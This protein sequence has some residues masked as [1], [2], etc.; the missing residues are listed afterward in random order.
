[1][2][3]GRTGITLPC[4]WTWFDG[5]GE[6]QPDPKSA[7]G[8]FLSI[9]ITA[10]EIRVT[11]ADRSLSRWHVSGK[12][13]T[14]TVEPRAKDDR[15]QSSVKTQTLYLRSFLVPV[16]LHA[17]APG[18]LKADTADLTGQLMD[19]VQA[20]STP[21]DIR[22][23]GKFLTTIEGRA[24]E[25]NFKSQRANG[26]T[27]VALD[28]AELKQIGDLTEE[29]LTDAEVAVLSKYPSRAP[30]LLEIQRYASAQARK[31]GRATRGFPSDAYRH[32]LWS[33][34]LT[35]EYGAEFALEL[36]T[37][38]EAG[39]NKTADDPR[40]HAMDLNNNGIGIGY[41]RGGI[42][43]SDIQW[44]IIS[45]PGVIRSRQEVP[46]PVAADLLGH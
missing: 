42:E 3:V 19:F 10:Q 17:L 27:S 43:E 39:E 33:Y 25:I 20:G 31:L 35:K 16:T 9:S 45:D 14:I 29:G 23:D 28:P 15:V 37:A 22:F 8:R 41:A 30:R 6:I 4:A 32:V 11:P 13:V 46:A 24:G 34:L 2:E 12:G 1:M 36:T 7:L 44:K 18:R 5:A 21:M 26:L 38:H 40:D